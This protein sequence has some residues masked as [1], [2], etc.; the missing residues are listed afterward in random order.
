MKY[1]KRILAAVLV[2]ALAFSL[3]GCSAFE[4]RMA[5][6]AARMK[7]V[8]N[9]RTDLDFHLD[10]DVKM[11]SLSLMQLDTE[12]SG[13]LD[14]DRDHE[15]AKGTLH[16]NA[17]GEESDILI[18]LENDG[19]VQ[20]VYSSDD[21]GKTWKL[22]ENKSAPESASGFLDIDD[23]IDLDREKLALLSKLAATFEEYGTADVHGSQATLYRGRVSLQD[24]E[25]VANLT[26]MR[27]MMSDAL[28][29]ELTEEDITAIGEMPVIL[30]IDDKSGRITFLALDMTET[31]QGITAIAMKTYVSELV[32]EKL[33]GL[34]FEMFGLTIGINDC[35]LEARL[36]DF[37]E[38]GFIVIPDNVRE[39]AVLMSPAF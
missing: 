39:S 26:L 23:M 25:E 38:V 20:R 31:M 16:V 29:T 34:D 9:C 28:E 13:T 21:N 30:G 8:D 7:N 17:M 37:N 36:Y 32:S 6:A 18:Y 3:A 5:K 24:F 33:G 19:T 14:V 22:N 1:A 35:E 12:V 4:T 10:A 11:A 2:L 15:T 27:E